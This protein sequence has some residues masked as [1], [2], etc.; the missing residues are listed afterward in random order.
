MK[1]VWKYTLTLD[2]DLNFLEMPKD[3]EIL[4]VQIQHGFPTLWVLVD[5][6]APFEIRVVRVAGTGHELPDNIGKYI[7]T[8]QIYEGSMIV[9]VFDMSE[10]K[11]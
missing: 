1:T 11:E 3:A 8:F 4:T 6:S 2:E 5:P 10:N 9:H 7:G